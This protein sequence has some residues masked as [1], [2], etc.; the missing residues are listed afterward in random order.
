[1]I[2]IAP[3]GWSKPG[4]TALAGGVL[5]QT[6]GSGA[7]KAVAAAMGWRAGGLVMSDPVVDGMRS[8]LNDSVLLHRTYSMW[9]K[10]P[11]RISHFLEH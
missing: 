8:R 4:S 1:M 11:D 3:Q 10:G 6:R 7:A 9:A 5:R 2:A